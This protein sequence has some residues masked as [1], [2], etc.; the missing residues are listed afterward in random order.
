MPFI[1]LEDFSGIAPRVA[2]TLLAPNQAQIAKNV[3]VTSG[4]LRS[5]K[6]PIIEYVPLIPN[7]RTIYKL[8]NEGSG[9]YRW[10]TWAEDVNAVRAP[11]YDD[12][13]YRVYYTGHDE[14][15]KTNW[16][17]ATN[18][19]SGS[20]PFPDKFLSLKVPFPPEAPTAVSAGGSGTAETRAYVYT[21]V[22]TFGSV[23]EESAP[24]AP[25]SV[26]TYV[27]GA[28]VTVA[29][30]SWAATYTQT[31]TL[32]TVT[33]TLHRLSDRD[34]IY[35][36]FTSGTAASGWYS[37]TVTGADTFTITAAVS[38]STSGNAVILV[39]GTA[40]TFN[41]THRRIYRTVVG[42]SQVSYQFV[43]EIPI[44]T[45]S[46]TDAKTVAQLGPLL[47]TQSWSPPPDDLKGLVAMPNGMLAAFRNNEVWFSEPY[48]PHAWPDLY[49]LVVGD[50]IVGL[51]VY[52]TTLVVL[53]ENNPY[54]ITG[55]SPLAM[56]QQKLP[57]LQ[58]CASKRSIAYD[59]YGVLYASPNGLVSI[60][61]AGAD[62]ISLP[63]Y[64][65]EEWQALIPDSMLGM[66]YNNQYFGFH[67]FKETVEAL[68]LSRGDIPPLIDFSFDGVAV[69]VDK[70]TSN[71]FAVSRYD[72]TIYQL[73]A[74]QINRTLYEWKSK[75]FLMP[76]PLSFGAMKLR[77][78][79]SDIGDVAEY[80]RVVEEI[81]G[82]NQDL[83]DASSDNLLGVMNSTTFNSIVLGGSILEVVPE[84]GDDKY[85]SV[86]IYADDQLFYTGSFTNE[87]PIRLPP[88]FRKAYTWE[89]AFS[90]NIPITTFIIATSI[91]ELKMVA[92]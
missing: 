11:I 46:I 65:R 17:L 41:I 58:P 85:I 38:A 1:K 8:Y 5:W 73:D 80:N 21:Y 74:S 82:R 60:S 55:S 68:V 37:V 92:E 50:K 27:T 70:T 79:Y 10:L 26:D 47:R 20:G 87:E 18:S 76:Q 15:K 64:A 88:G 53:T 66:I 13:D 28:T 83:W 36:N 14:P 45:V 52:D 39:K 30:M 51:G 19:G 61:P 69:F 16:A 63:L 81:E 6:K 2:P 91:D 7:V 22:S 48:H 67:N 24:S 35:I 4:D 23:S 42:A 9:A 84:F 90:G 71:I 29:G 44:S 33:Q 56:S 57:M 54:L 77:A 59:Q 12:T 72:N 34:T 75:K 86:F 78:Q 32:I 31:G 3:R 40:G 25:V 89:I 62:V 43:E 49:T